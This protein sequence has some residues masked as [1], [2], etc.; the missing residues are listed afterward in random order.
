MDTDCLS[1]FVPQAVQDLGRA[2]ADARAAARN[3]EDIPPHVQ[4]IV[5]AYVASLRDAGLPPEGTL[6]AFKEQARRAG[7]FGSP[8]AAPAVLARLVGWCIV[9][10]YRPRT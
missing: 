10:Y 9:E 6:V 5:C 7:I 8:G 3:G 2:L 4:Q 1:D